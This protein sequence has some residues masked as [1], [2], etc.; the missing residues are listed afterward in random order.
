MRVTK[1]NI[2][3]VK[4]F[5]AY[6]AEKLEI[7]N[8][9]IDVELTYKNHQSAPTAGSY[10]PNTKKIVVCVRN[11]AMA[12]CFRTLAHE[13]T[14]L[15]QQET[16]TNF[17][18]DDKGLQPLEDEANVMAGRLVRFFGRMHREIYADLGASVATQSQNTLGRLLR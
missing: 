11:R 10:D 3:L 12:D 18:S 17:P 2:Q 5:V 14:H 4:T 16:G 9:V 1:K 6:C 7:E 13:L 8:K 15:R